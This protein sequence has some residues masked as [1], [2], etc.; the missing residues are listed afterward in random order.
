M[1]PTFWDFIYVPN[2]L[3]FH[4]HVCQTAE[5]ICATEPIL[6]YGRPN[7]RTEIY[8]RLSLEGGS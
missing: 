7:I 3:G 8:G 2:I 6:E 1:F 5:E 4:S